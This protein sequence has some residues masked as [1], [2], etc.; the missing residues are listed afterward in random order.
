MTAAGLGLIAL[1]SACGATPSQ[2]APGTIAV[3][4]VGSCF[5]PHFLEIPDPD[6]PI[7]IPVLPRQKRA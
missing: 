5:N 4:A 7:P 3:V 1:V 6:F 2:A